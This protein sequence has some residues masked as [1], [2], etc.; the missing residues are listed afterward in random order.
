MPIQLTTQQGEALLRSNVTPWTV[1]PRP[2][3]RRD[4]YVNLNGMWDFAIHKEETLPKQYNQ[5]I[6]VP[7]CPESELS[8]VNHKDFMNC[9]QREVQPQ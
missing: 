9:V 1:Y 3:L 8:G 2:Q 7:F 6:R 4:S 5:Q